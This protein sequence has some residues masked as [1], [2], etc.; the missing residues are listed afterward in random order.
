MTKISTEIIAIGD[1]LLYGQTLD[2][3]SHWM[4]AALTNLGF[5]VIQVTTIGDEEAA[6]LKA[7]EA[8]EKRAKLI[9]TTGGLGPTQ[10]DRT[11]ALLA[12]YFKTSL[13]LNEQALA[14][15]KHFLGSRGQAMTATNKAQAMLP[16]NCTLI[17][18]KQGTAPGM[19]FEK[20]ESVFVAMPGVPHE[21]QAMMTTAILPKLKQKFVLPCIYYKI[22]KTAGIGE[23][24]LADKL[25]AWEANLPA[26]IQLA[27][28]PSI[29]EVK[30][31]LTA[32]GNQLQSLKDEVEEQVQKLMPLV[33][34][35][36]YAEDTLEAVIGHL[37]KAQNKTV[38]VAE[39]CSGGYTSYLITRVP[40]SS[41]YYQG[42]ITAYQNEVKINLLG[43]KATTLASH[44]AVSEETVI[45]MAQRVREK[46]NASIGISSSGIAGPGG[47]SQEK[48]VGTVWI[49]LADG[50]VIH[51][52]KLQLGNERLINVQLTASALLQL[53]RHALLANH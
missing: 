10:D 1:E 15:V 34:P 53:L 29:G 28:L 33:E 6:I 26:H 44:G 38:A 14:D 20:K 41:T 9:L 50:G 24:W 39:S 27:Y 11:K 25:K 17:R 45:E 51:T 47:G 52:K 19:W 8:A 7:L 12:R 5:K 36:G 18:N 4:S 3:N 2:T 46:F 13:E 16:K 48:P 31:R 35:Y 22:I 32:V 30:L 37:L 23:S 49:A 42:G 43:V 40:G 21:M